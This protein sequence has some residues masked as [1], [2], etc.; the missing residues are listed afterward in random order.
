MYI[1]SSGPESIP[2]SESAAPKLSYYYRTN[3]LTEWFTV[4]LIVW[5]D[6][7]GFSATKTIICTFLHINQP[8]M[9]CKMLMRPHIEQLQRSMLA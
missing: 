2:G 8:K 3:Y 9:E 5:N 6:T 7:V 4:A 1:S